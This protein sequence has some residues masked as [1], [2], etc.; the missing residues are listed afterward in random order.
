MNLKEYVK[1]K[2]YTY[3]EYCDYLKEKYGLA[4]KSYFTENFKKKNRIGK[5]NRGLYCH[6]IKEIKA[7]NLSEWAYA[8]HNPFEYQLPENLVY[9]DLLEHFYLHLLI[10]EDKLANPYKHMS[11]IGNVGIGGI[12]TF[13]IPELNDI[14]SGWVAKQAWRQRCHNKIKKD[15]DVYL[16]LIQ[17]LVY[18]YY[19]TQYT[20]VDSFINELCSSANAS[21]KSWKNSNNIELYNEIKIICNNI[22]GLQASKQD[23]TQFNNVVELAS[24]VKH[25]TKKKTLAIN[26]VTVEKSSLAK[27]PRA[28]R[29]ELLQVLKECSKK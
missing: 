21:T 14:Y 29:S 12:T 13:F 11:D 7:V 4:K 26:H 5:S 22:P 3:T 1:V 25:R 8:I 16:Q 6:H 20:S 9:C 28:S 2:N 17:R 10:V 19:R 27:I 23:V 15:K 18:R 24:A